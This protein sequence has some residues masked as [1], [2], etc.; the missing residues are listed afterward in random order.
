MN[1]TKSAVATT[2]PIKRSN[3]ASAISWSSRLE[4]AHASEA[5]MV[6]WPL[7]DA[8]L[9]RLRGQDASSQEHC[10]TAVEEP[11][12]DVED[13]QMNAGGRTESRIGS[14]HRGDQKASGGEPLLNGLPVLIRTPM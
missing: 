2:S 14:A 9:L 3:R 5:T 12:G 10:E 7:S 6:Q 4:A 8:L 13:L 11:E 1:S